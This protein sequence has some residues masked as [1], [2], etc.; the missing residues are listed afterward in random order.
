MSGIEAGGEYDKEEL[1]RLKA[2][3]GN[4]WDAALARITVTALA[5]YMQPYLTER[6]AEPAEPERTAARFACLLNTVRLPARRALRRWRSTVGRYGVALRHFRAAVEEVITRLQARRIRRRAGRKA[7]QPK[8]Y[9]GDVGMRDA[10]SDDDG[11]EPGSV[12]YGDDGVLT[13]GP[14]A[15]QSRSTSMFLTARLDAAMTAKFGFTRCTHVDED[16][17]PVI[18]RTH[19]E[20]MWGAL[21][22]SDEEVICVKL[23]E[24]PEVEMRPPPRL[25]ECGGSRT[26]RQRQS[27]KLSAQR[28]RRGSRATC[29][30]GNGSRTRTM[31]VCGWTQRASGSTAR[32]GRMRGGCG[33]SWAR[34]RARRA[35]TKMSMRRRYAAI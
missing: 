2:L 25:R 13:P 21:M 9:E 14:A 11:A 31:R 27:K 16:G 18:R 20:K 32:R 30:L 5:M 1:E 6:A 26:Y 22:A 7:R 23:E 3:G 28:A 17:M 12:V 19:T 24:R 35:F 29:R 10:G 15:G 34:S 4:T 33:S 8:D